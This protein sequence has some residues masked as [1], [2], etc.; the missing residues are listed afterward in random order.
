MSSSFFQMLSDVQKERIRRLYARLKSMDK[1]VKKTG[2]SK[3]TIVN[4]IHNRPRRIRKTPAVPKIISK[5][6]GQRILDFIRRERRAG[7]LVNASIIKQQI[8]LQCS[9]R[10]IAR[11]LKEE[12]VGYVISKKEI[13]LEERHKTARVDFAKH[14]V[15]NRTDFRTWIFT[16]E[17]KFSLDGPD[18]NGSYEIPGTPKPI[19][20]RRQ[21]G[22]GGCMVWGAVA[23]NGNVFIKASL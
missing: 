9:T 10:T 8:H 6:D 2:H 17:K 7:R 13:V 15:Q 4:V 21:Q 18:N 16:D 3:P 20:T 11:F 1:V 14:H 22:G 23:A 19:R 12:N 5:R